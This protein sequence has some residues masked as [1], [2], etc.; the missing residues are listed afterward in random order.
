LSQD[1][2]ALLRQQQNALR[3]DVIR[4]STGLAMLLRLLSGQIEYSTREN[5]DVLVSVGIVLSILGETLRDE[6]LKS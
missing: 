5:R 2:V 4:A 1:F 3:R 6:A